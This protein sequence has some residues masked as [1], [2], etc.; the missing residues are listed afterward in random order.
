MLGSS[1]ALPHRSRFFEAMIY[2]SYLVD[3]IFKVILASIFHILWLVHAFCDFEH[4][5]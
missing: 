5:S 3:A 2:H 1:K 4:S